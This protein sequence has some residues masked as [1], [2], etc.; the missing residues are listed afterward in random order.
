MLNNDDQQFEA[1]L[2]EFRPLAADPLP[3]EQ[4]LPARRRK[5]VLAAC[6]AAVVLVIV[7]A[8]IVRQRANQSNAIQQKVRVV[9]VKVVNVVEVHPLTI[10][11]A[12]VLLAR[13]ASVKS[14]LD[15][16]AFHSRRKQLPRGT[17]SA[18]AVL[19]EE[20]FKL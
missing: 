9:D 4:N 6:A 14:A 19:G 13:A 17:Q 16:L 2:R 12:N 11:S 7:A 8:V 10:R 3:L 15:E 20:D 18:L 5:L 1:R